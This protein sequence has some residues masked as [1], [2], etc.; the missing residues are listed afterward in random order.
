MSK[1]KDSGLYK[2]LDKLAEE[3]KEFEK[4][5]GDLIKAAVK[6]FLEKNPEVSAIRW[7]QYTPYFN[8]GEECVFRVN[9]MEVQFADDE[10]E[11]F[12]DSYSINNDKVADALGELESK[13]GDH[14]DILRSIFGDHAEITVTADKITVEEYEHE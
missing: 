4:R 2:E 5:G 1:K 14:E 7:N 9:E 11:D 3:K 10:D 13:L 6:T 12:I 8:D